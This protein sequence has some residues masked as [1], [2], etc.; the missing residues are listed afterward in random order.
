MLLLL[1]TASCM[2]QQTATTRRQATCHDFH[3]FILSS[4][5][6]RRSFLS[7][8]QTQQAQW[9]HACRHH[10][11]ICLSPTRSLLLSWAASF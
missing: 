6:L 3:T 9:Q 4:P 10:S 2:R 7:Q 8:S 11:R 1:L 5:G